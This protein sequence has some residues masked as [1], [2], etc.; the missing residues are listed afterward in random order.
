[1]GSEL[2]STTWVLTAYMISAA[3][4]TPVVGRAGDRFGT[5]RMLVLS[6]A[7][8]AL[9]SLL[10]ALAPTIETLIASRAL[11]GV[12][13]GIIPLTFTLLRQNLPGKA[14]IGA[15]GSAAAVLALGN[16][17]GLVVVGPMI[18]NL[19]YSSIFLVPMAL[20]AGAAVA[21]IVY[22]PRSPASTPSPL[23]PGASLLLAAW[24]VAV[25]MAVA[26]GPRWGWSSPTT[27]ALL[28]VG[29]LGGL[30]WT[31]SELRSPHPVID[32]RMLCSPAIGA[33]NASAVLFGFAMYPFFFLTPAVL[34]APTSTPYGHGLSVSQT[35]LILVSETVASFAGSALAGSLAARWGWRP[36]LVAGCALSAFG[37]AGLG[38]HHSSV[39][40]VVLYGAVL[41]IALGFAFSA[42]TGVVLDGAPAHQAGAATGANALL[43]TLA[44]AVGV[45]GT[46]S[47]LASATPP[48]QDQPLGWSYTACYLLLATSG[49]L[50]TLAALRVPRRAAPA[51]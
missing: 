22:I 5:T 39:L 30:A 20:A 15:I 16:G 23:R 41:G 3:V 6:L 47:I 34:Q 14:G 33:A 31:W 40:P 1:M 7:A 24:L 48:G 28:I 4:A 43:R 37:L 29:T 17:L 38:L 11:Q 49:L 26:Q 27:L 25:L 50:G 35:G 45:A 8:L 12:G 2:S 19:G 36:L 13:G 51:R 44:G 32:L 18:E 9:G 42:I 46:T 21:S 10:A